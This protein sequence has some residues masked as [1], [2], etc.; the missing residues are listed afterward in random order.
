MIGAATGAISVGSKIGEFVES[1]F[2]KK[3]GAT[4]AAADSSAVGTVSIGGSVGAVA[5][6]V[7]ASVGAS[8]GLLVGA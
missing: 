6:K 1:V 8:V 5:A 3:V 4:G 2:G 7:G